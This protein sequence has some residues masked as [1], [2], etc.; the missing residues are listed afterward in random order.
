MDSSQ[1]EQWMQENGYENTWGYQKYEPGKQRDVT[2]AEVLTQFAEDLKEHLT[3]WVDQVVLREG[4]HD[5]LL[6]PQDAFSTF[7][8]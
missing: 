4:N 7:N 8:K 3:Q 1:I 5:K 2:T 6:Y